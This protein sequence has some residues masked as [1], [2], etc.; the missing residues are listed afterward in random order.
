MAVLEPLWYITGATTMGS[1]MQYLTGV[2]VKRIAP[3]SKKK[4]EPLK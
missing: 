4:N 3:L 1:G 2:G